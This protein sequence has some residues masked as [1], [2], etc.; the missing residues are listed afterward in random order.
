MVMR[1]EVRIQPMD[2]GPGPRKLVTGSIKPSSA[3][4]SNS[5][6]LHLPAVPTEVRMSNRGVLPSRDVTA[7]TH[8]ATGW[9]VQSLSLAA[10]SVS[11][12]FVSAI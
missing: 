10:D 3:D 11:L 8:L 7:P 2:S 1:L 9:I 4:Q 5:L 6:A 12:L